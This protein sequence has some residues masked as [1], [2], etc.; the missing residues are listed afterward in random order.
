MKQ[1]KKLITLFA[2]FVMCLVPLLGN[3]MTANAEEAPVTFYVKYVTDRNEWC[4]QTGGWHDTHMPRNLYYM[5]EEI[6]DGSLLVID[7]TGTD[8]DFSLEVNVN[9]SNLTI[10]DGDFVFITAKG[11]DN[12]YAIGSSKSVIN[13]PVKNA[14]VYDSSLVN[15]NNNID[16]LEV[17]S[18]KD[19]LL[20]ATVGVTGTVNHLKAYS[21]NYTHFEFYSFAANTLSIVEGHL[22]TADTNYS[23]TPAATT[24]APA[25][26]TP[27]APSGEYDDV[28]KTADTGFNPLWLV[29]MAAA[30][31]VGCYALKKEN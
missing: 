20:R 31:F 12:F 10:V 13:A 21:K 17:I 26:S 11:V 18:S 23:K 3:T 27:S 9:L 14:Y 22:K 1:I 25:P 16:Y 5:Q 2:A 8:Q 19:E 6:K 30:C 24:P 4:F 28:P 29:A 15:F 7:S